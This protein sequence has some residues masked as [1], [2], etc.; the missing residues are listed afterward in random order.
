MHKQELIS[1]MLRYYSLPRDR[2]IFR[3]QMVTGNKGTKSKYDMTVDVT[4]FL[5]KK[6]NETACPGRISKKILD[7]HLKNKK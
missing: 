2:L 1:M 6:I 5:L 3:Y 4:S 7:E